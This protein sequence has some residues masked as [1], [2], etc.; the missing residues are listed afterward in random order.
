[1]QRPN[2][3]PGVPLW[4]SNPNVAGGMEINEP[5]IY[6]TGRGSPR[7]SGTK[8][9]A[10]VGQRTSIRHCG[11]SSKSMSGWL[12]RRARTFSISSTTP[13]SEAADQLHEFSTIRAG[14]ADAGC[15][16]RNRRPERRPQSA[17]SNQRTSF[18]ATG[19]ETYILTNL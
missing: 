3:V 5:G 14:D 13:T 4:I 10:R 18:R 12:F 17:V 7:K 1:M 15:I 6:R 19:P 16:A 9:L 8:C 2:L 11:G